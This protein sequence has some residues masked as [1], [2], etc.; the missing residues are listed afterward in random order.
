MTKT[1]ILNSQH[2]VGGGGKGQRVKLI[3]DCLIKTVRVGIGPVLLGRY[4][5]IVQ[6][7]CRGGY[8]E[9]FEVSL[10]FVWGNF[11]FYLAK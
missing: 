1:I 3:H 7:F 8:M 4:F 6:D 11:S 9:Y 5:T 2:W 10:Q